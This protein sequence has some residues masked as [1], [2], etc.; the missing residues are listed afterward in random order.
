[1]IAAR[2]ET[3]RGRI[4]AARRELAVARRLNPRSPL[5]ADRR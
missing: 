3:E 5:L 1:V 4:A 2:I